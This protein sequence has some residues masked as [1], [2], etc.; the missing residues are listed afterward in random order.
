[1]VCMDQEKLN[2]WAIVP[3]T[4]A[5]TVPY[6]LPDGWVIEEVPRRDGS[7]VD[8][9][10]SPVLL[11]YSIHFIYVDISYCYVFSDWPNHLCLINHGTLSDR[12]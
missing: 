1:M 5:A 4:C 10:H 3:S 9:V 7:L 6:D 11:I 2:E 8:K 12:K